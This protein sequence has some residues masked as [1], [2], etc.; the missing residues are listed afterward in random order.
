MIMQI[1][2]NIPGPFIHK[3]LWTSNPARFQFAD[4]CV[5]IVDCTVLQRKRSVTVLAEGGE[6]TQ[7]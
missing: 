2:S 1:V 5:E 4:Q 6:F 3:R 7:V